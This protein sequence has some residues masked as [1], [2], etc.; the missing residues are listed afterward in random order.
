MPIRKVSPET[1]KKLTQLVFA[2][3][4]VTFTY[5]RL[6]IKLFSLPLHFIL[7]KLASTTIRI[8]TTS[9]LIN[10]RTSR[11]SD[12]L[13]VEIMQLILRRLCVSD[14]LRCGAVCRSW[15]A[16]V[17]ATKP[18]GCPQLPWLMLR[19]HPFSLKEHRFLSLGDQKTYKS[20][21][22]NPNDYIS[23]RDCVGSVEGW[24]IMIDSEF[25][26]PEGFLYPWSFG[27][28]LLDYNL[29]YP[30]ATVNFFLNPVSGARVMLP[31]QSTVR[32]GYSSRPFFFTKVV[33]SSVPI[34]TSSPGH[35]RQL[36]PSCFVAGL[37]AGGR[38]LAFCRP[39]DKFWTRIDP[40]PDARR[41]RIQDIEIIDGRLFVSIRDLSELIVY[42]LET[43]HVDNH[44]NAGPC[45]SIYR[46]PPKMLVMLHRNPVPSLNCTNTMAGVVHYHECE[47]VYLAKDPTSKDLFMILHNV[48]LA[49]EKEPIIPS[50]C[51]GCNYVI[52]PQTL[53]FRV[54][55]LECNNS[56][57]RW[58]KVDDLGDRILFMSEAS[59]KV[60]SASS[61]TSPHYKTEF[62]ENC[63]YFAFD[64]PCL[65]SP[66]TGRDFGIFSLA[67]KS[68]KHFT[69]PG[70]EPRTGLFH[71]KT[72]WFTPN[73]QQ[74]D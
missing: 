25:W 9:P 35:H 62:E 66:S 45:G 24:L 26:R 2:I 60:I 49:Y 59:N 65:A 48:R 14:H 5:Y 73:F 64:N 70:E 13:T 68:I 15:R 71:S 57:S 37:S 38:Y 12:E 40:M 8:K 52:P 67:N 22:I 58:K 3:F 7:H 53:G 54:F 63:I 18:K 36:N 29:K 39:T 42:D 6:S 33:A 50:S 44:A 41:L 28:H 74:L 4:Q 31:S 1:R 16:A 72:V 43:L 27:L 11:W 30:Y 56:G 69:V 10:I 17:C 46:R 21:S 32:Y 61:L 34:T 19:S 51:L 23:R 20:S 55:K 47:N